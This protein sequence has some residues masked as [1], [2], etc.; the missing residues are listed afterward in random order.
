MFNVPQIDVRDVFKKINAKDTGF[1]LLDVRTPQEYSGQRIAGSINLPLDKVEEQIETLIPN[2]DKAV[3]VYCMSGSR[4]I[5]AVEIMQ[6][7]GYKNVY[8]MI[9]GIMACRVYGLPLEK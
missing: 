2:K 8:D 6:N 5:V 3:Y 7:L 1:V 4:S 9:S